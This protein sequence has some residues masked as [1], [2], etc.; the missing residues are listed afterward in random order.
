[1]VDDHRGYKDIIFASDGRV[2][3]HGTSN[4]RGEDFE[5]IKKINSK[6]CMGY[7]G[8]SG[9]FFEDVFNE[10]NNR[11]KKSSLKKFIIVPNKLKLIIHEKLNVEKHAMIEKSYGP[12]NHQFIVGEI[13]KNELTLTLLNSFDGF[14]ID[15]SYLENNVSI[16]IM[17][18]TEQ[19]HKNT[20][21]FCK[22]YLG[23]RQTMDE[24]ISNLRLIIS[25]I[26]KQT[27]EINNHIFIRRLSN[28]FELERYIGF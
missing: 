8:G 23:R 2:I 20:D 24:I 13:I 12:L 28:N 21:L 10:L 15:N 25:Q 19:I 5:K 14:H 17:G 16:R 11:I 9:E 18:S 6:T 26:A 7:V 22:E 27:Y 3:E 4:I 1:M